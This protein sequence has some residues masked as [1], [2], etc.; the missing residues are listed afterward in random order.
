MIVDA[1][2]AWLPIVPRAGSLYKILC[3]AIVP[4]GRLSLGV[5]LSS[6]REQIALRHRGGRQTR[7]A[8]GD[9]CL[10]KSCPLETKTKKRVCCET[11]SEV[12]RIPYRKIFRVKLNPLPNPLHLEHKSHRAGNFRNSLNVRD[13]NSITISN[14]CHLDPKPLP[15]STRKI[16]RTFDIVFKCVGSSL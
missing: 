10:R 9:D 1:R 6:Q 13:K 8:S 11:M 16:F 15:P 3:E 5:Y 14:Q 12:S 4:D 7:R 2:T